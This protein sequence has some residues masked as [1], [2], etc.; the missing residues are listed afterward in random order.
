M[1]EF[2]K[3]EVGLKNMECTFEFAKIGGISGKGWS[4]WELVNVDGSWS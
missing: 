1:F 3:L 2:A 4:K